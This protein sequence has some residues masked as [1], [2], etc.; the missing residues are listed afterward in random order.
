[1]CMLMITAP[2]GI[3]SA[4]GVKI[5][6]AYGKMSVITWLTIGEGTLNLLLDLLFTGMLDMDL[7]NIDCILCGTIYSGIK[8]NF[9]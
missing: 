2:F 1:M 8:H 3:V 5:L 7:W 4:C 9:I 6:S